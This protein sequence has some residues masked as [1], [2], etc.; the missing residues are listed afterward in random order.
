MLRERGIERSWYADGKRYCVKATALARSVWA[1]GRDLGYAVAAG[2]R[3]GRTATGVEEMARTGSESRRMTTQPGRGRSLRGPADER[4]AAQRRVAAPIA[5]HVRSAVRRWGGKGQIQ[6]CAT[7]R[8]AEKQKDAE[9]RQTKSMRR[10]NCQKGLRCAQLAAK[11][12]ART[13]QSTAPPP[14]PSSPSPR[15][16]VGIGQCKIPG[17]PSSGR[18]PTMVQNPCGRGLRDLHDQVITVVTR[19]DSFSPVEQDLR[20]RGYVRIRARSSCR[21]APGL[22]G[23]RW[24]KRRKRRW[25]WL[26]A[27]NAARARRDCARCGNETPPSPFRP[28]GARGLLF[29]LTASG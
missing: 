17:R 22:G 12:R 24:G 25:R 28:K 8:G 3:A 7:R 16:T 11:P 15:Q 1:R 10:L 2:T 14:F 27:S 21:Q 23:G 9:P 5:I 4:G 19:N 18:K 20:R 13:I 6:P 29:A 26:L